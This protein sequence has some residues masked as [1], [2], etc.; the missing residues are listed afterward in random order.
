MLMLTETTRGRAPS[1]RLTVYRLMDDRQ[2]EA[3]VAE[4]EVKLAQL[5]FACGPVP[6]A[7]QEAYTDA[8]DQARA[9]LQRRAT[10]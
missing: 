8:L 5:G 10:V 4:L 7:V 1:E 9:E 2:L 6:R 3:A